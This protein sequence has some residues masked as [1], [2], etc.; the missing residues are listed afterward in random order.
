VIDPDAIS[1]AVVMAVIVSSIAVLAVVFVG[2][3]WAIAATKRR[4]KVP[5]SLGDAR[6]EQ[7][8]QSIDSIAIEVER[9][10][11]AQR[12]TVKLMADRAEERL[13]R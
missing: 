8:Q 5:A 11:E 7:L 1:F 12:F 3:K 6:L 9:I 10:T 2:V 4:E 13:P